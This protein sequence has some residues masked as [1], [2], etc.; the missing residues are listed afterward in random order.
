[1]DSFDFPPHFPNLR[2]RLPLNV[3][4]EKDYFKMIVEK[5][6]EHKKAHQPVL[7]LMKTIK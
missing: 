7:V 6:E 2:K 1:V 3:C 5:I 4:E